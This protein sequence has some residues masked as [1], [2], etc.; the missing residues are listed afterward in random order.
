MDIYNRRTKCGVCGSTLLSNIVNLGTVPLAGYFPTKYELDNLSKFDLSLML[1]DGCKTVQ[2]DSIIDPKTLFSDYR[3]VSS[4]GLQNHFN[5]VA[6]LLK[7]RFNLKYESNILEIGCNDGVLLKPL[8]DLGLTP[9]GIDPASNIVKLAKAKGVDDI[10]VDFFDYD[11]ARKYFPESSHDLV[12]SNNTFAHITDIN[13]VLKGIKYILKDG[14][15]FVCEVHYL[16][17][18]IEDNQWDNIYHEHIYYYSITALNSFANLVGMTVVDFEEIPIHSGSIRVTM[19]NSVEPLCDKITN[20]ISYEKSIGLDNTDYFKNFENGM[21][22]QLHDFHSIIN[23]ITKN[24][25]KIIGYG[26]SGRANMFCNI[27]NVNVNT[28]SCIIDE[29]PERYGRYIANTEIP[30]H[31]P[32]ELNNYDPSNTYILIL[33]WNYYDM[34][35]TKLKNKGFDKFIVAFPK[36]KI[37][38]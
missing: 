10:H 23:D 26:A 12:V 5:E 38:Y 31:P 1:C 8:Q 20:R 29:S 30:I 6:S 24:N 17:N 18:L 13:S 35:T 34:I 36:P 15:H 3:Y 21:K 37:K 4:V 7:E 2:T 32:E 28:I 19:R 11:R 16:K 25:N 27:G 22:Q 33:A 14:G 9:T